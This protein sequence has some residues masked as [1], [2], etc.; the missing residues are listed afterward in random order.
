MGRNAR[1]PVFGV[2]NIVRFKQACS[3]TETIARK[4]EFARSKSRYDT[5]QKQN[6][7]GADQ[8]A[9]WSVHLLF[10]NPEDRFS[11]IESHI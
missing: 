2:S 7:K 8:M 11:R 5:F 6:N 1:K 10:A 9:A 4:L 3:A